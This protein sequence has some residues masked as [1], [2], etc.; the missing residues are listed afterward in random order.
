[1]PGRP[2]DPGAG[3]AALAAAGGAGVTHQVTKAY[4]QAQMLCSTCHRP[5][6]MTDELTYEHLQATDD[7]LATLAARLEARADAHPK[8]LGAHGGARLDAGQS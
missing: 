6:R 1:V 3:R 7:L 8:G 2:R 5:V 4:Q